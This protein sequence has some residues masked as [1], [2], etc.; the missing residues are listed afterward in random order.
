MPAYNS[1]LFIEE[2]IRSV[3][4]QTYK[5]WELI[6]IDDYST[7]NTVSLVKEYSSIDSRIRLIELKT[8]QGAAIARNKGLEVALGEFIA[9]LDSDDL[10]NTRKLEKQVDFMVTN[11][12]SFTCTDY[13][14]I[15]SRS[16]ILNHTVKSKK[17][18]TY[19]DL[20]KSCPGN[21]TVMYNKNKIGTI[22]IP[23]IRKRN[24]YL[25]W[26]K[27]IKKTKLLYGFEH[28]LSFHRVRKGS[29]SSS[30]LDLVRYH[31]IIYRMHEGLSIIKSIFLMINWIL[32][33]FYNFIY[34]GDIKS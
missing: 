12:Y 24:D 6:I 18:Y 5:Y 16:E 22:Q 2:S 27:L 10:W 33:F 17:L 28:T 25:F 32:L 31:W 14:K 30:K 3:L 9:F 11:D 4:N 1:E 34:N 15:N 8:N 23:N 7:D 26:L 13:G 20:L 21:S 19:N 29:I